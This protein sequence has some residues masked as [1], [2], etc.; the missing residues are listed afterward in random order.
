LLDTPEQE[1]QRSRDISLIAY[2]LSKGHETMGDRR[3]C[4]H[5]TEEQLRSTADDLMGALASQPPIA[6]HVRAPA[7]VAA[8]ADMEALPPP[9]EQAPSRLVPGIVLGAGAALAITGVALIAISR[10]V[11]S[12]D[13]A[14]A[15]VPRHRDG[16]R[17]VHRVGA[18]PSASA[19]PWFT[20]A[21]TPR[22]VADGADR[23]IGSVLGGRR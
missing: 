14:A 6:S 16:G 5:C 11:T 7:K 18:Q 8:A 4:H 21:L 2:W 22:A 23:L 19:R 1:R 3:V 13:P 9:E 15:D 10:D 12:A 17:R 20:R